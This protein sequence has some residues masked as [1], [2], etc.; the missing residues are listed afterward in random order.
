M[1]FQLLSEY[2]LSGEDRQK[3]DRFY[4][5]IQIE[6]E[7]FLGYPCNELFDYSPLFRFLQYPLNNVGDPY[8]PS[9]YHLNT[10]NFE[11]E[12]LEI[13]RTLTEATEGST[14]GYVT[15]GGT[16]GNHYG[17]FLARELLPEGLVYYSQDAHYS[18]D[19][20]LRCL[21]LRS[22]MIRSHDDGSM[23]LEDLRETLRI[24]RDLPPIV[25]ATIGTTMKGAVDD[26]AGIKSIFKDLAIHRHYIHADAALGGMILPFIDHP[27]AWNFKAG[28]DSIAI[29]GHKMVG[30]PIPCGVVLA[31]KS[32]VERIAQSVEYIGTLDT[33]LSGSRN[34]LTPLFLWYAFHTVGIEGFKRIIPACLKMADYAIAQ[35]NKIN[36]NAWRYPY[37]NTVVFDRPSPEVTR[38]WQLACQGN[39]S[40]LIT[41]PHVT[42]TQIDHLVADIIASEPITSLPSLSVTPACELI[43]SS[44][45]Q[46]I[47]LIGTANHNLL[48]EV[49]TALAAEGL[50]IENLTA[51]AVESEDVE[52]VRL[53]V[54]NRERALQ[55]LNQNL[56]IG[57]CYG[58]ARSFGNEEATQVLSQLEYQSVGEDALLVE[59]DDCPG[60]LAELLKDCRN[61]AVKI[62]NIRLL[63]RGHGK[64]VV[65]I[66]TTAPEALKTLLKERILLS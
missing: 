11:C 30:S 57:R 9:N 37:S 39:L 59:L 25:C 31:K 43:T 28:I 66:A 38:Y 10:H 32:N 3:L 50:S 5:E 55:I 45:D 46:D 14:W 35:L 40:H 34:A 19:K 62:R 24:H 60:S 63:W 23:D 4:R 29:S 58:Q 64:G 53:R 56:D 36:R 41:M 20:I 16:E 44:P 2:Q 13:F 42:S 17:L 49:S 48:S 61:E 12:V 7:R 52:V 54:D 22:I 6:A 27:P 51:V 8:L 18:I 47:T 21:N 26:I 15:N 33:T 1:E 65:A